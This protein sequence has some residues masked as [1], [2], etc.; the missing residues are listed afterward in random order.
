MHQW[1]NFN[2]KSSH[3]SSRSP[4]GPAPPFPPLPL[5]APAPACCRTPATS[6]SASGHHINRAHQIALST[7]DC[8]FPPMDVEFYRLFYPFVPLYLGASNEG[9][10]RVARL[11]PARGGGGERCGEQQ[12][13]DGPLARSAEHHLFACNG[14]R[15]ALQRRAARGERASGGAQRGAGARAPVGRVS[16]A[17]DTEAPSRARAVR[18]R[19]PRAEPASDQLQARRAGGHRHPGCHPVPMLNQSGHRPLRVRLARHLAAGP[20]SVGAAHPGGDG[21]HRHH[22]AGD[23]LRVAADGHRVCDWG[24]ATA[25]RHRSGRAAYAGGGDAG[26]AVPVAALFAAGHMPHHRAVEH[27][28]GWLLAAR[29]GCGCRSPVRDCNV[30]QHPEANHVGSGRAEGGGR[31]CAGLR[32]VHGHAHLWPGVRA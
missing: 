9:D 12:G 27:A 16:G 4:H 11:P 19:H 28:R 22:P 6:A 25:C 31:G 18:R 20:P 10:C 15:L 13:L 17:G 7:L 23:C 21:L 26:R 3:P 5:S 30:E 24:R 32:H 29:I 14:G 8:S 1:C 2:F